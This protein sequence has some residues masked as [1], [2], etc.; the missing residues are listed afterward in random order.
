[1]LWP[2]QEEDAVR[3]NLR[4]ALHSLRQALE[5]PPLPAGSVLLV[6]LSRVFLDRSLTTSDVAE[7]EKLVT[8][9]RATAD[10]MPSRR[11]FIA[12]RSSFT[13]VNCC[14]VSTRSGFFES[15]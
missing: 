10:I 14:R 12:R 4:Q 9:A 5:P 2:D 15:A 6:K 11:S 1:M 3:R 13:V 7:F 8:R